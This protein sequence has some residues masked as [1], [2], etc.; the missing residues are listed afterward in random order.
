MQDHLLLPTQPSLRNHILSQN[1]DWIPTFPTS[2]SNH[3][4]KPFPRPFLPKLTHLPAYHPPYPRRR[5]SNRHLHLRRSVQPPRTKSRPPQHRTLTSGDAHH[6]HCRHRRR[7]EFLCW[8]PLAHHA[9]RL[10][11]PDFYQ[12]PHRMR[13]CAVLTLE[14]ALD[15]CGSEVGQ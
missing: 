4:E 9:R 7:I 11:R 10:L 3:L 2:A 12:L 8:W 15:V 5:L 13:A 6:F 14:A 1:N